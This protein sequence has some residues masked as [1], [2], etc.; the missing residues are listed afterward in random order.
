MRDGGVIAADHIRIEEFPERARLMADAIRWQNGVASNILFADASAVLPCGVSSPLVPDRKLA[1]SNMKSC[2]ELIITATRLRHVLLLMTLVTSQLL[3][4]QSAAP[5]QPASDAQTS[6][7]ATK[8]A[9][10]EDVTIRAKEQEK[11]GAIYHLRGDVEV[12]FRAYHFR[13]AEVTYDSDTGEVQATGQVVF[14]GGERNEHVEASHAVY[15]VNTETGTFYDV[16][17]MIGA[18]FRGKSIILTT[19]NPFIFTGKVVEKQGRNR[20]IVHHG[21][22]TSCTLPHPKW[23]F[24]AEKVDV[25][26]GEDA[27]IYHSTFRIKKVP[28]FYFPYAQHPVDNLGRQTGFL[29]PSGGQSSRKG[30][31]L[32]ESFYWAINRSMDATIGAEYFSARGWSQHGEFRARPSDKSYIEMNYFGVLDRGA[33]G[34]GQDQ[35]GENVRLN[36]ELALPFGFRGVASIDYLSSFLFRLAFSETFSQAVNSEAKSVA[37]ASKNFKGYSFDVMSSRYQNFQSTTPGD[38]IMIIHA[39]TFELSTAE[40]RILDTRAMWSFDTAIEGVSRREPGLVTG[41]LVGR[42]DMNPRIS[43]PMV[44]KGWSLR[45]E[46]ALRDT[47]YT[48]QLSPTGGVG[49]PQD[50]TLNRRAVEA[51]FELRPPAVSRIFEKELLGRKLKHTIEPRAIYRYVGGVDQ[52]PLIIRFDGRDIL[53]DT[54]EIEVGLVNRLYAKRTS[55]TPQPDCSPA[56]EQEQ[57]K[58]SGDFQTS[59]LPGTTAVP[60]RCEDA[61]VATREVLKWEIGQKYFLNQDFGGAIV[62]GRRNVFTTSAEFTGIAFLT[63]PRRWSPIISRLRLQTSANTDLQWN[64]DYDTRKGRINASTVLLNYRW[65]E[66]FLG[67]SHAFLNAPGEVFTLTNGAPT[68]FNQFRILLGYGH[69]NKRGLS[70]GTSVGFDANLQFLQYSSV[71]TT[72]NW[73]CCGF[74]VE[75]RRF[76]LGSVRNE[77]QFRFAF[78]LA[79]IGTFG[80]LRRQ[81]RLF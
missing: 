12:D 15:N 48:Q 42:F 34:T 23:T 54:S 2:R 67:G 6:I 73:D 76:A 66:I 36:A 81:E 20:Y 53:S 46:V 51:S 21:I 79:N 14:D 44:F 65:R 71:Q 52:F 18:R 1:R 29:L 39:P 3:A 61:G 24:D 62:N 25:V 16:V 59:S 78:T 40:R 64:L 75:Y 38:R 30:T 80:N 72:Y 55:Q 43:L 28:I 8:L 49:T 50:D 58:Q 47:F 33:P 4:A 41:D 57:K 32:G 70:A 19:S 10:G 35:G 69:P 9:P 74:S 5:Q 45:P 13:A 37:F 11:S 7:P 77:N 31:I 56:P 63:E 60:L 27:K 68:E 17:G 26:I 22:I